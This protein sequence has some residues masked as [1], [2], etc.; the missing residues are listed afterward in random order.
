MAIK[1]DPSAKKYI[2][3]S[4]KNDPDIIKILKKI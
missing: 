3:Q 2:H 4:L 1:E